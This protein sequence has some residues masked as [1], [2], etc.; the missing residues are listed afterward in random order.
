[1]STNDNSLYGF[2]K[3]KGSVFSP[4]KVA[5][6]RSRSK[7]RDSRNFEQKNRNP[8]TNEDRREEVVNKANPIFSGYNAPI[9]DN[10]QKNFSN[11]NNN[12]QNNSFPN[13]N[14]QP[15][16]NNNYQP[17]AYQPN[18][19]SYSPK[20]YQ[21]NNYQGN[22]SFSN[23]NNTRPQFETPVQKLTT[24]EPTGYRFDDSA[25]QASQNSMWTGILSYSSSFESARVESSQ[26]LE[27]LS[28]KIRK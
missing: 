24:E 21:G 27:N 3:T 18:N 25:S 8:N 17:N 4:S 22:N 9:A 13:N 7:S 28:L 14:Y 26:C 10:L 2:L 5:R 19:N 11:A 20:N 6:K 1:M 15:N 16:N 12:Y 23:N